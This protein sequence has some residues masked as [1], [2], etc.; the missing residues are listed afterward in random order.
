MEERFLHLIR[1]KVY[2]LEEKS[3]LYALLTGIVLF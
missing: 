1:G 3:S 2:T